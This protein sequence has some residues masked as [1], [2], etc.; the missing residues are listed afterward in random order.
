MS[1][2]IKAVPL[3]WKIGTGGIA[4]AAAFMGYLST[5]H[6]DA[7]AADLWQQH[8]QA[9]TCRSVTELRMQIRSLTERLQFDRSLTPEQRDWLRQEIANIQAEIAR[10]DPGGRC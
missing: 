5:F 10:L 1:E 6:T 3:G 2:W 4:V 7:E 8:E 9:I